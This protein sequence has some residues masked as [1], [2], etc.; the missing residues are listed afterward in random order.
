MRIIQILIARSPATP[1]HATPRPLMVPHS[2]TLEVLSSCGRP[3]SQEHHASHAIRASHPVTASPLPECCSA[4]GANLGRPHLKLHFTSASKRCEFMSL[5]DS[6]EPWVG[7]L[8][9]Y[10]II[11]RAQSPYSALF[12]VVA[13]ALGFSMESNMQ[14][15]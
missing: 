3:T 8:K 13:G 4:A 15:R 5:H 12:R 2:Q 9:Y 14:G 7:D 11:A 1:R 10:C 6:N